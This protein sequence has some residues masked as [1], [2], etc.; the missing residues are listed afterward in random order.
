[1]CFDESKYGR[2]FFM[3][4][5]I[6]KYFLILFCLEYSRIY[7]LLCVTI[8]DMAKKQKIGR[9]KG[10]EK[11]AMNIYINKT[12]AGK[13]RDYARDEQKTISIVIENALEKQYGI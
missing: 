11:E 10:S 1:M 12:R 6:V 7:A 9:P 5:K 4:K 2:I 3:R 8:K 13:L